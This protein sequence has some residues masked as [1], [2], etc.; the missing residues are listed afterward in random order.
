M[1]DLDKI[2]N[3]LL[4]ELTEVDARELLSAML[5]NTL[6][7][8]RERSVPMNDLFNERLKELEQMLE[9]KFNKAA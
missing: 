9:K 6:S 3:L 1:Q 2:Y 8:A 5:F 4:N 7:D